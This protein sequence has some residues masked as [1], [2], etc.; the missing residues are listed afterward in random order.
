MKNSIFILLSLLIISCNKNENSEKISETKDSLNSKENI[1]FQIATSKEEESEIQKTKNLNSK[2]HTTLDTVNIFS[3]NGSEIKFEKNKFNKIIDSHP[4]FFDEIIQSPDI[5][6]RNSGLGF[7]SEAGQDTYYTLY[8]YFL[9]QRNGIQKNTKHRKKLIKI[10]SNINSL[11]G[12]IAYGGTYFGHQQSRLV[13]DAEYAVYLNPADN[14][15]NSKDQY[16]V[17]EQKKLYIQSLRQI[18]EDEVKIDPEAT[19]QEKVERIKK[20]NVL[21]NELD[22]LITNLF[23]LRCAQH[24]HYEHY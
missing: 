2:Y 6:Y 22:H 21:V 24:F 5:N 1:F 11:F 19:G 4:E 10:Y 13:A 14:N 8:A 18:I 17:S 9:K 16:D 20:M 15:E 3:G 23:Y 12:Y 7:S